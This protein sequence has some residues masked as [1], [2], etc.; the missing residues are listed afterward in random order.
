[1]YTHIMQKKKRINE[2]ISIN[3]TIKMH[4]I[5]HQHWLWEVHTWREKSSNFPRPEVSGWEI[6][7]SPFESLS[8]GVKD[9]L[10]GEVH[11]SSTWYKCHYIAPRNCC[12]QSCLRPLQHWASAKTKASYSHLNLWEGG[13]MGRERDGGGRRGW[14]KRDCDTKKVLEKL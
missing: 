1:M 6:M 12:R 14:N 8:G 4:K 3:S 11:L 2:T 9:L 7:L 13:W 5:G 10:L